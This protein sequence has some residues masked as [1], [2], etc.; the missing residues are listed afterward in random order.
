MDS[1]LMQYLP[2]LLLLLVAVGFAASTLV[3]SVVLGKVGRRTATKD[4]A[5]ECGMLPEGEGSA[6]MSVKFYLVA[7]LF[8]L[9][10]IEVIFMFPWAIIYKQMLR[11]NAALILGGMVSFLGVLFVGFLYALKKRAFDWTR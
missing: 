5:Y 7:L 3:I 6:R 9:F 8:V 11:E 2:V 1:Q 4:V 10:D